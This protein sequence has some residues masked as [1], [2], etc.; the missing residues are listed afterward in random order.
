MD[1]VT[2]V[3][4]FSS[5]LREQR[6]KQNLTLREL[7]RRA[8]VS[9]T[10]VADAENGKYSYETVRRMADYFKQPEQKVL[11]MAGMLELKARDQLV[12]EIVHIV[13][14][15]DNEQK[16]TAIA[17]LRALENKGNHDE[18]SKRKASRS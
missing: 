3:Y 9:H 5:W 12:D 14:D 8:G 4:R 7:S 2:A 18:T 10:T 15:M 6:S 16:G 11:A 1:D 13:Q 17:L